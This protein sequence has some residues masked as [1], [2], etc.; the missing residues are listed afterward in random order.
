[1]ARAIFSDTHRIAVALVIETRKAKGFSQTDLAKRIGRDQSAVS[2]LERNQRGLDISEF[3]ELARA[4][5]VDPVELF[6]EMV[7]RIEK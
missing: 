4:M 6:S 1:M 2:H 3:Y 7:A 5:D